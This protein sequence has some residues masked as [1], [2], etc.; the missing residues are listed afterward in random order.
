MKTLAKIFI[1]VAAISF[2]ACSDSEATI[3]QVLDTVDT[4]SGAVLRTLV[5]FPD[6]VTITNE[7]NNVINSTIE[8]Q[9][10]NGSFVPDFKEVNL[11]VQVYND[12]DLIDPLLTDDGNEIGELFLQTFDA[13]QFSISSNG[14]PRTD[15]SIVVQDVADLY[16]AQSAT[17]GVPSFMALRFEIVMNNGTVISNNNVGVT[18]SGGIYFNSPFL[19]KVIFLPI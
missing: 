9:Q 19:F 1:L 2:T 8:V 12:Q 4:E 3:N 15:I 14:L 7:A 16:A 5:D 18:I 17:P 13:S 11:Y 6:L 10:G